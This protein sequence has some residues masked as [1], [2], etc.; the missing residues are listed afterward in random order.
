MNDME[1]EGKRKNVPFHQVLAALLDDS[2]VFPPTYLHQ[3]SDLEGTDLEA[4]KTVWSQINP[5]RRFAL[6]EDLENLAESDTLVSFESLGRFALQDEDPHVRRTAI[7]VLWEAE[8]PSL[9]SVFLKMLDDPDVNVRATAAGAL[10]QFVYMGEL[11]ELPGEILRQVE[12]R[13]LKVIKGNDDELVRRRALEAMGFSG[14]PEVPPLLREAYQR[15]DTKWLSSVLFA[16][17]RSAD[18]AWAPEVNRMLRHPNTEVQTEAVRA[19]GELE[20]SSAQRTLLKMLD[21]DLQ[22]TELRNAIIWALSK[23]GGEEVR[24]VFEDLVEK[25]EDE[26]EAEFMEQAMQNLYFTNDMGI[27]G[28]FDFMGNMSDGDSDEYGEVEDDDSKSRR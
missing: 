24:E 4:L 1:N 28:M 14:R 16:M 19:A 18:E 6:L 10:G 27:Y 22:E 3:F 12:N 11:E 2:N 23:I 26:E 8:D 21:D 5:R 25:T 9:A 7:R 15:E 17:G 13:L 20:L